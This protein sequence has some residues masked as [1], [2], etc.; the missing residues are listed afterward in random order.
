MILES[1]NEEYISYDKWK[2]KM[3][4]HKDKLRKGKFLIDK[5]LRYSALRLMNEYNLESDVFIHIP[6][7]KIDDV[8]VDKMLKHRTEILYTD[9]DNKNKS[10][11]PVKEDTHE[12]AAEVYNLATSSWILLTREKRELKINNIDYKRYLSEIKFTR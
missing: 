9:Y 10:W 5:D 11:I 3:K 8:F 6:E 2:N 7:A 12:A 4:R 1:L